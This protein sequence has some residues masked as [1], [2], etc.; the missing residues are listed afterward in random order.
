MRRRSVALVPIVL[1]FVAPAHA[2][3]DFNVTPICCTG[4][5]VNGQTS[6]A[7]SLVRGK[8]Y[9][10]NID[11]PDHPFFIKTQPGSGNGNTWDEGVTNNGTEGGTLTFTVPA[12]APATL[13]YQCGVH[14]AMTGLIQVTSASV[15]ALGAGAAAALALI[16]SASGWVVMRR[17]RAFRPVA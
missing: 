1:L 4:W 9:T 11:A 6:P 7:L 13:Y 12:D 8:T 3:A 14:S 2:A 15:P 5:L 10:F 17:G 16:A